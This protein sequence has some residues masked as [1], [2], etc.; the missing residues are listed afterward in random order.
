MAKDIYTFRVNLSQIKITAE[1]VMLDM[2]AGNQHG[3]EALLT[4]IQDQLVLAK[5]YLDLKCGYRLLA[6]DSITVSKDSICG[7]S[8]TFHCGSIITKQLKQATSLAIF[9]ATV[10][11]KFDIIIKNHFEDADPI[12]GY[13]LDTIGSLLVEKTIDWMEEQLINRVE[14]DSWKITNRFS[15]GYCGWNVNEQQ[16]LFSLLPKNFCGISLTE[17]SLMMPI[18]SVSGIIGIGKMVKRKPYF[19]SL[20]DMEQCYRRKS[21]MLQKEKLNSD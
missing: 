7:D 14:K 19:C 9:A 2:H 8:F 15:P 3:D 21:I 1:E 6:P 16:T 20:C 5:N 17:T 13:I 10:G 4:L 12:S 11:E 18:K